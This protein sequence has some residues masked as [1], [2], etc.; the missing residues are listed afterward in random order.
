VQAG[1]ILTLALR[2]EGLLKEGARGRVRELY[3]ADIGVP[4]WVYE[5]FG[6]AVDGLFSVADILSLP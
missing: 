3:L 4:P 5:R 1:A 6:F 2:K